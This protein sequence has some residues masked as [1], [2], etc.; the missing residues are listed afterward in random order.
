MTIEEVAHRLETHVLPTGPLSS[1]SLAGLQVLRAV[2]SDR[3]S[4]LLESAS[5]Q[6]LLVTRLATPQLIDM[7]EL[8]DVPAVCVIAAPQA[9]DPFLA[10]AAR[11]R[12]AVVVSPYSAEETLRRLAD[13]EAT[14]APA[15]R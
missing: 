7:A 10:A 14:G 13:L 3:M 9:G 12:V 1:G 2:A 11:S 4:D 6:T 15:S 8:M 5:A